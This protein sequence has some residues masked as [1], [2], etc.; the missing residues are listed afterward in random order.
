MINIVLTRHKIK[1]FLVSVNLVQPIQHWGSWFLDHRQNTGFCHLFIVFL[2]KSEFFWNTSSRSRHDKT[3]WSHCFLVRQCGMKWVHIFLFYKS[4]IKICCM[5]LLSIPVFS[6]IILHITRQSS[7][8]W[9][10]TTLIFAL[11]RVL[12]GWSALSLSWID[13][14]PLFKYLYRSNTAVLHKTQATEITLQVS[15]CFCCGKTT[16]IYKEFCYGLLFL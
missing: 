10:F 7:T 1:S 13:V 14:L 16:I 12:V 5:M 9:L 4:R 6:T 2:W 11:V 8:S 3:H 15:E